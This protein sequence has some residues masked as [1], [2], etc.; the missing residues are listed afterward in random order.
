VGK[1]QQ[2]IRQQQANNEILDSWIT[3]IL[4]F[5]VFLVVLFII[6]GQW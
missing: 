5:V 4:L 3:N 2:Q 6:P 1:V